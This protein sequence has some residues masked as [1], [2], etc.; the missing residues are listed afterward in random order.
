MP[1]RPNFIVLIKSMKNGKNSFLLIKRIPVG[2]R[3]SY[4][5]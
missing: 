4:K 5:F 3:T 1:S 2:V